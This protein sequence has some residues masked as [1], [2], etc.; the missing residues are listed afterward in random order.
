MWM[1]GTVRSKQQSDRTILTGVFVWF[2][3]LR[4]SVLANYVLCMCERGSYTLTCKIQETGVAGIK[5]A[6]YVSFCECTSPDAK[7]S[8]ALAVGRLCERGLF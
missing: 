5:L 6:L 4:Y 2:R 8:S 7:H 1:F 3:S